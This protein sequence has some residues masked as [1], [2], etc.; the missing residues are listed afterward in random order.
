MK[1]NENYYKKALQCFTYLIYYF[2]DIELAKQ[3]SKEESTEKLENIVLNAKSQIDKSLFF[4]YAGDACRQV[5][6]EAEKEGCDSYNACV[7][8]LIN[9]E[10]FIGLCEED[11]DDES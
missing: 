2:E 6:D 9:F 5:L 1:S 8:D 10:Y 3:L 11:E 4:F 7:F